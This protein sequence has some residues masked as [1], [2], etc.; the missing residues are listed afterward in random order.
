MDY[1]EKLATL[2]TQDTRRRPINQK[3]NT[4]YVGHN[5]A[6]T[7]INNINKTQAPLQTTGGK[8]DQNII[9]MPKS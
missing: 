6:Q 3:Q 4:Q 9:F 8:D 2:G 5:Y 7:D 1:S